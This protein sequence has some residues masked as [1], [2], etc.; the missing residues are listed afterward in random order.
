MKRTFIIAAATLA[1]IV[2]QPAEARRHHRHHFQLTSSG[3]V[4]YIQNPA[5][6]WRVVASCAHRLA[7]YWGLGKGLDSV[8][9]W[10]QVFRRTSGPAVGVA[11]VRRDRHHV[12]GIIG[13]GPGAWQVADFNSG[14]HLN[15]EYTVAE[16]RGYF[17]VDPRSRIAN[18]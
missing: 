5:G 13:G 8:S 6:T 4:I 7:A 10:S 16:F 2:S 18:R 14:R 17:F 1:V 12:M 9:T 15:R 3:G 11:A